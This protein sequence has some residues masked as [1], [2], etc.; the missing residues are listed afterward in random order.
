MAG[1][2]RRAVF[3]VSGS[4]SASVSVCMRVNGNCSLRAV[5][6]ESPILSR[7]VLTTKSPAATSV[8]RK[9][10]RQDGWNLGSLP[11][12]P[13]LH[14]SRPVSIHSMKKTPVPRLLVSQVLGALHAGNGGLSSESE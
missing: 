14:L 10:L 8:Q 1:L 12:T 11:A 9:S 6:A 4:V 13:S 2:W 7:V 5:L 3:A